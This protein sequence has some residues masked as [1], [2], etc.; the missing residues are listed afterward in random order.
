M[1]ITIVG[2]GAFGTALANRIQANI[3]K[4]NKLIMFGV[5]KNE[6]KDI[7]TN[8]LNSKYYRIRLDKNLKAT[9]DPKEAFKDCDLIILALPSKFVGKSV[10]ETILPNITKPIYFVNVS[11]GFDFISNKTLTEVIEEITPIELQKGVLKLSGPSFASELMDKQPTLFVLASKNIETAK[12]IKSILSTRYIYIET[13]DNIM[14]V[15]WVS[16]I[17]NSMALFMGIVAGLGYKVNTRALFFSKALKEMKII[18]NSMNIDDDILTSPA[19]VGDLFL[20]GTSKKSR[21]FETGYRIGK[22]NKVSKRLLASFVTAEGIR[23]I[24]K[25]MQ[26]DEENKIGLEIINMLYNITYG[27]KVP[28]KVI[29]SYFE[30]HIKK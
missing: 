4:D 11:K 16:I 19:G 22:A 23:T 2:T 13:S 24:E 9:L 21:N 17:K 3:S 10:K 20:T 28:S 29:E 6:V 14:G 25:L 5:D 8:N 18:L 27:N 12:I 1:N 30:T 15:E 7:N 26:Y